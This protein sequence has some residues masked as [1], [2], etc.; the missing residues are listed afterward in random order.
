MSLGLPEQKRKK[1]EELIQGIAAKAHQSWAEER[2][3]DFFAESR[4]FA[5]GIAR[6][7]LALGYRRDW[8]ELNDMVDKLF[9]RG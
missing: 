4:S 8:R 7:V 2:D 1:V 3:E 9:R 5:A 6:G